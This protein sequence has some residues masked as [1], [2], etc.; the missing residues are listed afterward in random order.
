ML[1]CLVSGNDF[2]IHVLIVIGP[3]AMATKCCCNA[4]AATA[5]ASV[6]AAAAAAAA[7]KSS[8]LFTEGDSFDLYSMVIFSFL[9]WSFLIPIHVSSTLRET[10]P[11]SQTFDE[12]TLMFK[13]EKR[14]SASEGLTVVFENATPTA[15]FVTQAPVAVV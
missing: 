10:G 9:S 14:N 2:S 5:A 13:V 12:T 8:S 6:A 1:N 4:A 3:P 15:T 7:A 11:S